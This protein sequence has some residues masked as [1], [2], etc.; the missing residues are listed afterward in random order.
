MAR[1]GLSDIGCRRFRKDVTFRQLVDI[2]NS[3]SSWILPSCAGGSSAAMQDKQEVGLG[4]FEG[5]GG[6]ASTI[7]P[8]FA[9]RP[10]DF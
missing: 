2:A 6:A 8:R 7:M 10:M 3:V 1:R 5:R 9:L 4:H